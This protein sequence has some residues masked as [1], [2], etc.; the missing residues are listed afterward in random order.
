MPLTREERLV[1][2]ELIKKV[3]SL[4]KRLSISEQNIRILKEFIKLSEAEGNILNFTDAE[5]IE[6]LG[7]AMKKLIGSGVIVSL[8]NHKDN[9]SGG[10]CFAKL[11][12]NLISEEDIEEEV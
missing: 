12:A 10:D 9:L 1:L 4:E 2:E 11:G 8:H 6:F 5:L 3:V 7:S